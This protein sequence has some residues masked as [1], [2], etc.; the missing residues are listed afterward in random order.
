MGR[1]AARNAARAIVEAGKQRG[2][3]LS[4]EKGSQLAQTYATDLLTRVLVD[5]LRS[6]G[7]EIVEAKEVKE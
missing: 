1:E 3:R 4:T 7:R 6:R 2:S 5:A